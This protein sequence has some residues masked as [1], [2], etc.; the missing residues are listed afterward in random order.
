[1]DHC[2]SY[3]KYCEIYYKYIQKYGIDKLNKRTY[4]FFK[5]TIGEVVDSLVYLIIYDKQPQLEKLSPENDL[6]RLRLIKSCPDSNS[7]YCSHEFFKIFE[8]I[9]FNVALQL[10]FLLLEHEVE[11]SMEHVK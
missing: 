8:N 1:M 5:N 3:E 2:K 6:L 10:Y 11:Q 9:P 7:F 4:D